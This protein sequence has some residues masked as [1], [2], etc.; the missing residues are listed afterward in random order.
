MDEKAGAR[1][2]DIIWLIIS[3]LLGCAIWTIVLLLLFKQQFLA[4]AGGYEGFAITLIVS[5]SFIITIFAKLIARA[6]SSIVER[7]GVVDF[8]VIILGLLI[9]IM[10]SVST[11]G[12]P[13]LSAE[14]KLSALENIMNIFCWYIV[15]PFFIFVAIV[16]AIFF[17]WIR[18]EDKIRKGALKEELK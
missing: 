6:L 14:D 1:I 17:L 18:K 7:I 10:I 11:V 12:N 8:G 3:L 13:K 15:L 9:G 16:G 5:I 4:L 2:S